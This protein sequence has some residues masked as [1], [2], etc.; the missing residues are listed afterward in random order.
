MSNVRQIEQ[1]Q[2]NSKPI[3]LRRKMMKFYWENALE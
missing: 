3:R 1:K 2:E